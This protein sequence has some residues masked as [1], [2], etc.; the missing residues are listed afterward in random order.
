MFRAVFPIMKKS[1]TAL[2]EEIFKSGVNVVKDV[3]KH[4]DL[5]TA[6]KKRGNELL[7][8]ISNRV[9]DHMFGSGYLPNSSFNQLKHSVKTKKTRKVVRKQTK[10]KP[11]KKSKTKKVSKKSKKNC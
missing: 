2:G 5:V 4:G 8:N 11:T 3:W 10:K 1:T 9:A 6:Q 7:G